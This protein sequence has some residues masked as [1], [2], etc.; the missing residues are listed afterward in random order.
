[1]EP[2]LDLLSSAQPVDAP[3]HL[4]EGIQQRISTKRRKQ[5]RWL[6]IAAAAAILVW[7]AE[8]YVLAKAN[9]TTTENSQVASLVSAT[10]NSL[11]YE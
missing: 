6:K 5:R 9:W 8:G 4:I 3:A 11:Y 7:G 10:N 2:F 1:M